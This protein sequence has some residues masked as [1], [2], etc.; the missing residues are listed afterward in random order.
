MIFCFVR[1]YV[2]GTPLIGK[3]NNGIASYTERNTGARAEL[4]DSHGALFEHLI[5]TTDDVAAWNLVM[6]TPDVT[7]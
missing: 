7:C 1:N 4:I 6:L 5:S 2:T 3:P